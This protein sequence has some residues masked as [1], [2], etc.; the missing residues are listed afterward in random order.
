[1]TAEII[2]FI[3]KANLARDADIPLTS[4]DVSHLNNSACWEVTGTFY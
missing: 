3:P 4:V 2:Q 1:M